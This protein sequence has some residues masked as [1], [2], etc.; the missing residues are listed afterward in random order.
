MTFEQ[1]RALITSRMVDFTGIDQTRIDYPNQ[2]EVF[3]TPATGLWC[4]LNIQHAT[5]FMA[6]MA[7]RPHTRKPGQISIQCFARVRTGIKAIN[8]LAD[9]LEAHFAYWQAG[10]L[11]CMEASQVVAG[12]FEDFYQINVNIRFRAG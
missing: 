9:A 11:E 12:E 8:E 2:K 1:I 6:G 5:A 10:D 3:T 7:D 4:R